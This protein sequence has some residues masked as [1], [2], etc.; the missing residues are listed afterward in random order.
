MPGLLLSHPLSPPGPS[1]PLL[2]SRADVKTNN[3]LKIKSL[4]ANV[5]RNNILGIST[6]PTSV[7]A[8]KALMIVTSISLIFFAVLAVG[9][10]EKLCVKQHNLYTKGHIS[11]IRV[12]GCLSKLSGN[13]YY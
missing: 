4:L 5:Q 10:L 7:P 1:V 11:V 9:G 2:L 12:S 13:C 8:A 3:S 6:I